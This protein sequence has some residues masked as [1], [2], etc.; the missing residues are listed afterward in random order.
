MASTVNCP[1]TT[2]NTLPTPDGISSGS[3]ST[4]VDTD[5]P[6]NGLWLIAATTAGADHKEGGGLIQRKFKR[7]VEMFSYIIGVVWDRLFRGS[8]III[9]SFAFCVLLVR[10]HSEPGYFLDLY[11]GCFKSDLSR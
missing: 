7:W 9:R 8:D 2:S 11:D 10:V 1:T 6:A 5:A 4:N 3:S